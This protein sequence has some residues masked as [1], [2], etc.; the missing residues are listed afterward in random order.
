MDS[1]SIV[2]G[3]FQ[4][5]KQSEVVREYQ[6]IDREEMRM[7]QI[8]TLIPSENNR[9][10]NDAFVDELAD[11]I[12]L[13]GLLQAPVVTPIDNGM[14]RILTG[15]HRVAACK[16]L[17][18]ADGSFQTI[19]CM[20]KRK[21]EIDCELLMLD[22]NLKI[23][24]LNPYDRMMAIGR[25]EELLKEKKK[26]E[27]IKGGNIKMIIAE[28]TGLKRSQVQTYLTIYKKA[29]VEVKKALQNEQITLSQAASLAKKTNVEQIEA[30]NKK[31]EN[32]TKKEEIS[33]LDKAINSYI[34]ECRKLDNLLQKTNE[35]QLSS[36]EIDLKKYV[37]EMAEF[38][39]A[40]E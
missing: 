23:N 10:L 39:I 32:K 30:M 21:D 17:N 4:N 8:D 20:I 40:M 19:R 9:K 37:H 15:H 13:N 7:L 24:T 1:K 36:A 29:S 14:Y 2:S 25:K 12:K 28:E 5:S 6:V 26:R 38:L 22:T 35:D 31:Q 27:Q 11:N 18:K 16:K 33:P 34:K 3:L